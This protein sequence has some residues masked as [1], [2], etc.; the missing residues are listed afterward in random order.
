MKA[1]ANSV[2]ILLIDNDDDFAKKSRLKLGTEKFPIVIDS[3]TKLKDAVLQLQDKVFDLVILNPFFGETQG[4][5]AYFVVRKS[6]PNLPVLL[7]VD[8]DKEAAAIKLLD[9]GADDYLVKQQ[10]K[11]TLLWH[12]ARAI[13]Q[14]CLM[15]ERLHLLEAVATQSNDAVLIGKVREASMLESK[16]VYQNPSFGRFSGLKQ[17][18]LNDLAGYLD[19]TVGKSSLEAAQI[20]QA[21]Q[22]GKTTTRK[23]QTKRKDGSK[24]WAELKV[25]TLKN[26]EKA[27]QH[28]LLIHKDIS[29]EQTARDCKE[30]I[31]LLEKQ[32]DFMASLAHDL[33]ASVLSAGRAY[34]LLV[35]QR[36]GRLSKEQLEVA[37]HMRASNLNLLR[38]T[39]NLLQLY[40]IQSTESFS[41]APVV[42]L[43][44]LVEQCID[45]C[46]VLAKGNKITLVTEISKKLGELPVEPITFKRIFG[47]L[48]DHALAFSPNGGTVSVL[49]KEIGDEIV[50][51]VIDQGPCLSLDDQVNIF[52]QIWQKSNSSRYTAA[53][54]LALYIAKQTVEA[55]GGKIS[56]SSSLQNGTIIEVTLPKDYLPFKSDQRACSS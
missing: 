15:R 47:N 38:L 4:E 37:E 44:S 21:M 34:D 27:M 35:E 3:A 19:L 30:Q 49:A 6:A 29:E 8:S 50:V 25:V 39:S 26:V 32:Q 16:L 55:Y 17:N 9:I 53:T 43:K 2:R 56:C 22:S 48:I 7:I 52:N 33:K 45:D 28:V 1:S 54:S 40:Q 11:P 51:R 36:L 42:D 24:F 18:E 23:I 10:T 13:I 31:S 12:T 14:R 41:C 5:S 20:L 46:S